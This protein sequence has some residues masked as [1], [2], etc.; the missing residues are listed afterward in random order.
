MPWKSS[1]LWLLPYLFGT[2]F[3]WFMLAAI[4]LPNKCVETHREPWKMQAATSRAPYVWP[5]LHSAMH[6]YLPTF[7]YAAVLSP[8]GQW[9]SN[10]MAAPDKVTSHRFALKRTHMSYQLAGCQTETAENTWNFSGSASSGLLFVYSST[11]LFDNNSRGFLP[12]QTICIGH[13]GEV[14]IPNRIHARPHR[15]APHGTAPSWT[16]L[17]STEATLLSK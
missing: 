15:T 16:A 4:G 5:S 17:D 1:I 10:S 7:T 11:Y 2:N 13:S 14:R 6:I 3:K 12:K 8:F 9:P